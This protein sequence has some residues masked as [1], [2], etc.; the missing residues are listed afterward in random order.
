MRRATLSLVIVFALVSL[1][2]AADDPKPPDPKSPP[3]GWVAF[4]LARGNFLVWIPVNAKKGTEE[5]RQVIIQNKSVGVSTLR[6]KTADGAQCQV[7]FVSFPPDLARLTAIQKMDLYRDAYVSGTKTSVEKETPNTKGLPGRE[8]LLKNEQ[9]GFERVRFFVGPKEVSVIGIA[10]T[11]EQM[12][13]KE[14]D[15]FL[16]S[17]VPGVRAEKK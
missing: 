10:G 12:G 1:V 11:K 7:T 6:F 13:S 5:N 14:A 2:V 9:G 16:D 15:M 8:L 3:T 4:S 17:F